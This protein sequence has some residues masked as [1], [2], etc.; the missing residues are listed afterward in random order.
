MPLIPFNRATTAPR[1]MQ[2]LQSSFDSGRLSGDGP[3]TE[4]ATQRLSE[5]HDGNPVLLTPSCTA[6]LELAAMALDLQPGDEVIVPSFTFVSSASA[7][8]L[9]GA[10]IVFADVD[11]DTFTIG[12]DD[13]KACISDR[14]RAVVPVHYGGRNGATSEFMDLADSHQIA[15]VEDNAH[16]LFGSDAGRPLGTSGALST[17]SFH[18]T[19]NI[20]CG[21]GGALVVLDE[22]LVETIE[23]RREK[24]TNRRQ[25]YRGQVDKYSWV[26][27]GSS[28]LLSDI[29]AAVLLAQLEHSCVIQERRTTIAQMYRRELSAWAGD[30]GVH[31]QAGCDNSTSPAHLFALL[32]PSSTNRNRF[33]NHMRA[34]GVQSVFHYV[35]LHDS[36]AGRR[37]GSA[38]TGCPVSTDVSERLARLP[39]FS[40][41]TEG[42]ARRVISAALDF[43]GG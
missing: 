14:T 20:S 26:E 34:R 10:T 23:I 1:Q 36:A 3:F 42:E 43:Q 41:Q 27:L 38:P 7:F 6:A 12:V 29:S 5:L 39:L 32:F 30:L 2:Y 33:L 11:P 16:G 17:L 21:E 40:D 13:F 18:E 31:F 22:R 15:V 9:M 35:P 37:L 4:R 19:K 24:G 25:F 28:Y 8:A